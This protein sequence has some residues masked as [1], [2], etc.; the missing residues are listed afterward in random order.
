MGFESD[1]EES[2]NSRKNDNNVHV[3]ECSK[4]PNKYK[5]LTKVK[6]TN[7]KNEAVERWLSYIEGENT[8]EYAKAAIEDPPRDHGNKP[9]IKGKV[10][11]YKHSIFLDSGAEINVIDG[12]FLKTIMKNTKVK[13]FKEHSQV[14]IRCANG[15]SMK[16]LGKAEL[17]IEIGNK[18][19][20]QVF[21]VVSKIKPRI[22]IGIKQMKKTGIKIDASM[23]CIWLDGER[24][25]FLRN[26]GAPTTLPK[27]ENS[28]LTAGTTA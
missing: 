7:K 6:G 17:N 10:Q 9:L 25:P 14:K 8:L 2:V 19:E 18:I 27:N 4:F 16:V 26:I 22:I 24:V 28:Q 13:L 11:G 15:T 5:K 20:K 23:D 3:I 1:S 12:G 21:T